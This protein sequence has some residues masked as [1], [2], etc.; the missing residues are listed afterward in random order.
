MWEGLPI[1]ELM[2]MGPFVGTNPE[3]AAN[4]STARRPGGIS[5]IVNGRRE[6]G[7]KDPMGAVETAK[8]D[9]FEGCVMRI[10]RLARAALMYLAFSVRQ[11]ESQR[12]RKRADR[13]P[14]IEL[15]VL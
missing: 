9:D 14:S 10:L 5:V 3:N 4:L 11:E 7:G 12:R 2:A 8:L 15:P 1:R 6:M 13:I